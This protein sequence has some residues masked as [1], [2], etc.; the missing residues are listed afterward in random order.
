MME[1][2]LPVSKWQVGLGIAVTLAVLGYVGRLAKKA[3]DEAE[4]EDEA[5]A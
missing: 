4:Q 1:G 2:G 5:S 3:L